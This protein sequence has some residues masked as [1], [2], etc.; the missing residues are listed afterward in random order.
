MRIQLVS[1]VHL[2]FGECLLP[3]TDADVIVAAGDIG[4]G[5]DGLSWLAADGRP[6]VYVAGNHEFYGGDLQ[7]TLAALRAAAQG[8][9]V[10]VLENERVEIGG[11]R[12]LGATLWTD[13]NEGD[14]ELLAHG[15]LTM[16]DYHQI[17][18]AGLLL[19]PQDTVAVHGASLA[20]LEREL[21]Q[22][23]PGPTVVVT[24]HA[25][26]RL[27]WGSRTPSPV[28]HAYC[29]DLDGWLAARSIDLWLHG[30]IHCPS[31]YCINGTRVVCNPR[32]YQGYREVE[33]FRADFIVEI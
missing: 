25:P 3:A 23:F 29:N 30:H 4:V 28:M 2:E 7:H 5:L 14:R 17:T 26:T 21:A 9:P 32:G 27:S 6:V 12:F 18:L 31:D 22:P 15:R 24:H 8:T 1:D 11:V 19:R 20:W 16:N 10:R 13:F 33:T